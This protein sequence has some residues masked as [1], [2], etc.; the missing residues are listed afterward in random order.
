MT[1]LT[2][3]AP[4]KCR[5]GERVRGDAGNTVKSVQN[6]RGGNGRAPRHRVASEIPLEVE[7]PKRRNS[8]QKWWLHTKNDLSAN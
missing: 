4:L 1:Q 2:V 3:C 6:D 5:Q 7:P 8:L